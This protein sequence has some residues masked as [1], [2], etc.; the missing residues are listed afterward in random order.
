[1]V[2]LA[3]HPLANPAR[4]FMRGKRITMKPGERNK[5][6]VAMNARFRRELLEAIQKSKLPAASIADEAKVSRRVLKWFMRGRR[7]MRLESAVRVCNALGL[8][9]RNRRG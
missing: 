9:V 3:M 6:C 4:F 7:K 2:A 8:A 1:M 5:D